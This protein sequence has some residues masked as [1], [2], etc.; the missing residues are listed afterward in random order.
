MTVDDYCR[1]PR[2]GSGLPKKRPRKRPA[3]PMES[4]GGMVPSAGARFNLNTTVGLLRWAYRG[5]TVSLR[6]GN[7][8]VTER[9][10]LARSRIRARTKLEAEAPGYGK[11]PGRLLPSS[12]RDADGVVAGSAV[13]TAGAGGRPVRRPLLRGLGLAFAVGGAHLEGVLAGIGVPVVDP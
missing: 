13:G 8:L 7:T 5:V 3:R 9:R 2:G 1:S 6:K 12:H 10:F 4:G 11:R